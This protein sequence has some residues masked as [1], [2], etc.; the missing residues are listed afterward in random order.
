MASIFGK[1]QVSIAYPFAMFI[2]FRKWK[3]G[4]LRSLKEDIARICSM[5]VDIDSD[6]SHIS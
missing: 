2:K 6:S 4:L 5:S 1:T 3:R